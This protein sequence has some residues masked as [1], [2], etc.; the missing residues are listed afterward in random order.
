M[1]KLTDTGLL[2]QRDTFSDSLKFYLIFLVVLG[3]IIEKYTYTSH[4][5]LVVWNFIYTFHMPL[6]VFISGYFSKITDKTK[7]K[8]GIYRILEVFLTF[9]FLSLLPEIVKGTITFQ[10]IITPWW[11]LWYLFS[12]VLWRLLIY[13]IQPHLAKTLILLIFSFLSIGIGFLS[14]NG[15]ILSLSRTFVFFPF[16]LLGFYT[17]TTQISKIRSFP[18]IAGFLIL[19]ITFTGFFFIHKMMYRTVLGT[20]SYD[21][22]SSILYG[23]CSR[24]GFLLI[25]GILSIA[26]I[27]VVP[28]I[29]FFS[30]AGKNTLQ[31]YL[32]HGYLV[33]IFRWLVLQ[34]NIDTS[35]PVLILISLFCMMLIYFFS[36]TKFASDMLYPYSFLKKRWRNR[37]SPQS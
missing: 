9:H 27:N 23:L 5:N 22:F 7:Y 36:L 24:A 16:F 21:E 10:Q 3:H 18:K 4:L 30:N 12:L 19:S 15:Y 2:N 28:D 26:F 25:A 1:N 31:Y 13:W 14:F 20:F 29:K 37:F 34:Y 32:Y 8:K 6:F 17:N 33:L 35:L 11:I